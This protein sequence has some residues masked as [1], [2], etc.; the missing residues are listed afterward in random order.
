MANQYYIE[1]KTGRRAKAEQ[2][3][4][5]DSVGWVVDYMDEPPVRY[6]YT[7]EVFKKEFMKEKKMGKIKFTKEAIDIIEAITMYDSLSQSLMLVDEILIDNKASSG[8]KEIM[9]EI[10]NDLNVHMDELNK[11][12]FTNAT[13]EV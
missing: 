5:F 7:D 4:V 12:I 11:F 8:L 10:S 13:F 6:I 2:T 3:I 9:E 1:V